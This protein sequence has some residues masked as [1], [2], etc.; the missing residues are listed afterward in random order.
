MAFVMFSGKGY[1]R[2]MV[3]RSRPR[4]TDVTENKILLN[5]QAIPYVVKRSIRARHV[6][7]EIRPETGLTVVIPRTYSLACLPDLLKKK[8]RWILVNFIKH[9]QGLPPLN[10]L[11]LKSGDVVL[12][13]GRLLK[14]VIKEGGV[15]GQV[16]LGRR[17][18]IVSLGKA[19]NKLN[20]MLER[21]YRSQAEELD[22]KSV[23]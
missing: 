18:L 10:M 22:R 20:Y 4:L 5:G 14:V 16:K 15:A 7:L 2:G 1:T 9:E 23:V 3:R 8:Q 6:R 11:Q 19:S 21:W 13:L 12:Y 17:M